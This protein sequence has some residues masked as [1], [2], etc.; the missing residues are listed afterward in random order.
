MVFSRVQDTI[1]RYATPTAE[2]VPGLQKIA[3]LIHGPWTSKYLGFALWPEVQ[4][5]LLVEEDLVNRLRT[6]PDLKEV[7]FVRDINSLVNSQRTQEKPFPN[8]AR[9]SCGFFGAVNNEVEALIAAW[10]LMED[11]ESGAMVPYQKSSTAVVANL[12]KVMNMINEQKFPGTTL[13]PM[14]AAYTHWME[15]G[16]TLQ[17]VWIPWAPI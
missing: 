13:P 14:G 12:E 6:F 16:G 17:D 10:P 15:A 5:R 8:I 2:Q 11:H 3:F 1:D 9:Y 4:P 7:I